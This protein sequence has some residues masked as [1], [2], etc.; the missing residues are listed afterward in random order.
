[1]LNTNYLKANQSEPNEAFFYLSRSGKTSTPGAFQFHLREGFSQDPASLYLLVLCEMI[2]KLRETN[3][4]VGAFQASRSNFFV[5]IEAICCFN[6]SISFS[7]MAN[8][9]IFV[10]NIVKFIEI[11]TICCYH[12]TIV[13]KFIAAIKI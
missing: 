13:Q 2:P 11:S 12:F 9:K 1:M 8:Y 5:S 3:I 6:S 7:D 10:H 4:S